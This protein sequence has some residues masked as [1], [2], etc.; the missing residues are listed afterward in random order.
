MVTTNR[1]GALQRGHHA[2]DGVIKSSFSIKVRLPE[3][4]QEFEIALPAAL[5]KAFAEGISVVSVSRSAAPLVSA[6]RRRG[7]QD[8][9]DD[10]ARRVENQCVPQV[11]RNRLIALTALTDNRS[12]YR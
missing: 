11:S 1:D 3:T 12:L 8:R 9:A 7:R 4:L 5:V 2:R 6:T 10:F